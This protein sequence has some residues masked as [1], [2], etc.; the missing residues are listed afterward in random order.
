MSARV[1]SFLAQVAAWGRGQTDVRA[2]VV[3]GSQA[4]ISSPADEFSDVDLV[5]FV[6]QP[7]PY[8]RQDIWLR[9]FG[10]PLLTLLEAKLHAGVHERRVLFCDGL[11]V[12]FAILPAALA[13]AVPPETDVVLRRGY[14]ILYGEIAVTDVAA[15]AAKGVAPKQ[16]QLD[17]LCNDFWYHTLWA[18]KK[19]RRGELLFAKQVCDC[20]L[21]ARL[22]DL[23]RWR[24]YDRETWHTYRFFEWWA[25][26]DIVESLSRI[27]ARYDAADIARA[28]RAKGERF[29]ELENDVARRFGLVTQANH[30]EI[31][32]RLDDLLTPIERN[33]AASSARVEA[34]HPDRAA[35]P[36]VRTPLAL[37]K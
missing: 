19:L 20:Y 27:F 2:I 18:A 9:Q 14:R 1:D 10:K 17:E 8:L 21:T 34:Q 29:G 3:V 22:V 5:L 31:L 36:A 35:T 11:E 16:P 13:V 32:S 25:G 15:G 33:V 7:E 6:D 23:A 26:E 37:H 24:A 4:R 28:L 12:D 30:R